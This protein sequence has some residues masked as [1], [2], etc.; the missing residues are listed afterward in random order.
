MF[1]R[2]LVIVCMYLP[3]TL[4]TQG[5]RSLSRTAKAGPR[6]GQVVYIQLRV[7]SHYPPPKYYPPKRTADTKQKIQRKFH[8]YEA[9]GAR[10][11]THT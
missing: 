5:R 9:L 2:G 4:F 7:P 6:H 3:T 8:F 11:P 10:A 1:E